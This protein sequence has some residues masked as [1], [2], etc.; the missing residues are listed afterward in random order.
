VGECFFDSHILSKKKRKDVAR[1]AISTS[2]EIDIEKVQANV[3]YT[4]NVLKIKTIGLPPKYI[5]FW[6]GVNSKLGHE[7]V[8]DISLAIIQAII[9]QKPEIYHSFTIHFIRNQDLREKVEKSNSFAKAEYL[10][11]GDWINVGRVPINGYERYR[12]SCIF[13]EN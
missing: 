8:Q 1:R 4:F 2:L 7:A 13:H 6:V 5:F 3:D 9:S 12:L 10:P 11:D